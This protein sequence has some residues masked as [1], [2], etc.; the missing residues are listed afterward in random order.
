MSRSWSATT[1]AWGLSP[2]TSISRARVASVDSTS[3]IPE[4]CWRISTTGKNVIPWP[5]ERHRP[6]GTVASTATDWTNSS[7]RRDFPTPGEPRTVNRK[8]AR[9]S[10]AVRN[11]S[12]S[13]RSCRL[14]PIM[15]ESSRRATPAA[16]GWTRIRREL[17]PHLS[18]ARRTRGHY[19]LGR[20]RA[21]DDRPEPHVGSTSVDRGR[22]ERHRVAT[23]PVVER[24]R[25]GRAPDGRDA[26]GVRGE[27]RGSRD[28]GVRPQAAR[29]RAGLTR[30]RGGGVPRAPG[31][32]RGRPR[33]LRDGVRG[34]GSLV[35]PGGHL[36]RSPG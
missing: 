9:S 15:G 1:E 16:W 24:P 2:R 18:P 11:A 33:D 25:P 21:W 5:Y 19:G 14:R 22:D 13:C 31:E 34:P 10:T 20:R 28:G 3:P 26:P 36:R 32:E 4:A 27:D 6:R 29:P 12:T 17:R 8:Q 7:V 23:G 30:G 35:H